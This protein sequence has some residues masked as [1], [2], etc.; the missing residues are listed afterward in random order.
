M[1]NGKH[2]KESFPLRGVIVSLA[3]MTTATDPRAETPPGVF[4]LVVQPQEK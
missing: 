4:P 3:D 2:L 1:R